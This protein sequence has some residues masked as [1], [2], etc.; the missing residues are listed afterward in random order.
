MD[1]GQRTYD[2]P[3][4]A[5]SSRITTQVSRLHFRTRAARQRVPATT[6]CSDRR[7]IRLWFKGEN[8]SPSQKRGAAFGCCYRTSPKLTPMTACEIRPGI[9]RPIFSAVG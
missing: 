6:C 7:R 5:R 9:S 8:R 4:L 1:R 3:P 2:S